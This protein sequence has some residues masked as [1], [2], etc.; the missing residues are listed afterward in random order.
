M[1]SIVILL[2]A[3]FISLFSYSEV[4]WVGDPNFEARG[5]SAFGDAPL[6]EINFFPK[7][8]MTNY[9]VGKVSCYFIHKDRLRNV[10]DWRTII[11]KYPAGI[12]TWIKGDSGVLCSAAFNGKCDIVNIDTCAN[13]SG[14]AMNCTMKT[15]VSP[16]IQL[17]PKEEGNVK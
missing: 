8:K 16:S 1:K 5:C 3:V 12:D 4:M 13:M 10:S 2:G 15:V 7:C 11:D 14:S 9:C 17:I 6:E